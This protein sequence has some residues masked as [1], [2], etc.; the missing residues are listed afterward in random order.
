MDTHNISFY[1]ELMKIILQL[2]WNTHLSVLLIVSHFSI[3]HVVSD[4]LVQLNIE[5]GH[6][7][8]KWFSVKGAL[9]SQKLEYI[10]NI[11]SF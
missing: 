6:I 8:K 4:S 2:S 9:D 7:L 1:G 5:T 11:C 10:N 3:R